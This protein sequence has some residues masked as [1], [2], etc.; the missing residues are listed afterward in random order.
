MA[1][2][3][4]VS[5]VAIDKAS[6]VFRKV[7]NQMSQTLRPVTRAQRQMAMLGREMRYGGG[8]RQ[9]QGG[10]IRDNTRQSAR[11][12]PIWLPALRYATGRLERDGATALAL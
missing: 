10:P 1:N 8:R 6:A 5:V 9:L 7:N 2:R 4:E 3:F 12:W 11:S